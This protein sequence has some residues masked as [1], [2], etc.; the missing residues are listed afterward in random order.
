MARRLTGR[1][2]SNMASAAS[3]AAAPSR[4]LPTWPSVR[5]STCPPAFFC[6]ER[7]RMAARYEIS[8]AATQCREQHDAPDR[9]LAEEQQGEAVDSEADPARRGHAVGE[10][11]D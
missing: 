5:A 2:S 9:V 4:A 1:L 8:V 10:G 6:F 7:H 3:T 11:L